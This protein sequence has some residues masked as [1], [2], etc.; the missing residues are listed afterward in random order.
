MNTLEKALPAVDKRY[1]TTCFA[2]FIAGAL[3]G[4]FQLSQPVYFQAEMVNLATNLAKHGSFANPFSVL[5]TGYTAANPPGYPFF[6]AVLMKF[7]RI[8]FLVFAAATTGNIIVNALT[9]SL[10]PRVSRLFYG[11]MLPGV[12]ASILWMASM[13]LVPGWDADYT[14]VGLLLFCLCFA[15]FPQ[16]TVKSI[17]FSC[18]AGT[19]AGLLFLMNPSSV[20]VVLPWVAFLV[21]RR[22][23]GLKEA[24]ILLAALFL[25][26]F[27]WMARNDRRLG[28]F[29]VRTNLGMTLYASDND[30]AQP[31]MIADELNH[32]Y[33]SH[34]PNTSLSEAQLVRSLGEVKYSHMRLA[35][36]E[37]WIKTHPGKFRLLILQRFRDFWFPP[38]VSSRTL[39]QPRYS[40]WAIWVSTA[41][42]IPG[43]ILMLYRREF[44]TL[45]VATVLLLYPLMYYVVVSDVRY[46]YPVLWLTLLPAGYCVRQVLPKQFKR[47]WAGTVPTSRRI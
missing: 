9:A 10:L 47:S 1:A 45:F 24:A 25:I 35:D 42:S 26:I 16:G 30:C 34:H 6:L 33:Q 11:D 36:T 7:L 27:A 3:V 23:L 40:T 37:E 39:Q 41:L 14:L 38:L 22:R 13:Q 8:Q 15:S 5:K 2:L 4:V 19:V 28:A 17:A 12:V 29:V 46:R 18:L 43:L 20:L 31:S 32:C 21:L 44:V